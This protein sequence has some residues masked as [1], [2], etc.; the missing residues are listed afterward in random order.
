MQPHSVSMAPKMNSTFLHQ[1]LVAV[2][3]GG[4]LPHGFMYLTTGPG[5]GA[6]LWEAVGLLGGESVVEEAQHLGWAG[7]LI[8]PPISGS[9]CFLCAEDSYGWALSLQ[10]PASFLH[11]CSCPRLHTVQTSAPQ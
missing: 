3:M 2:V 6:P 5:L 4:D 1:F 10:I 11:C 8:V 9:F 7:G